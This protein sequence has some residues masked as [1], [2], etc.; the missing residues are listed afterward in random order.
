MFNE[1][2]N[3]MSTFISYELPVKLLTNTAKLPD[4]A[5]LFDAGLDLYCDEK[6]VVTLA[7][8][9][10]K[11][12]STGISMAIPRGFVGLIWPRSGHAVKKGLDT[13][14]GVID[15]PYRGEVKVLLVNHDEDYQVYSPGDKIAQ[16]IVQQV[17]DFTPVAVDNLNETSRGE[18]GFGSSGS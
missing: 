15:S 2:K 12:F 1:R 6:E 4:K 8:G 7:P 16:M 14:A 18:N 10:R 17:P 13:M 5:N 3:T 9:Q 11:L